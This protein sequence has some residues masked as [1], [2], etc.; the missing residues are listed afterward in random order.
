VPEGDND[1][2]APEFDVS[3]EPVDYDPDVFRDEPDDPFFGD[4]SVHP[5]NVPYFDAWRVE[6]MV[7]DGELQRA[8]YRPGDEIRLTWERADGTSYQTEVRLPEDWRR[9]DAWSDYYDALRDFYYP[10][11]EEETGHEYDHEGGYLGEATAG[12]G[13]ARRTETT[14]EAIRRRVRERLRYAW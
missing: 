13:L 14:A 2:E 7:R 6:D 4:E 11:W 8:G 12:Y 10:L 1:N 5:T 3:T 9:H